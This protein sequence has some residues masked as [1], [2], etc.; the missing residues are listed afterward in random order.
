MAGSSSQNCIRS[1]ADTSARLPA[2]TKVDR[3]KPRRITVSSSGMP[4]APDW[5]KKPIRP[6]PGITGDS[7]ALSDR[8]GS[9]LMT[10]RQFG[11]IT[12]IPLAR[13]SATSS[14]CSSRPSGPAS[15]N[16]PLTTTRPSTPWPAQSRTT[17]STWAAGTATSARSTGPGRSATEAYVGTPRIGSVARGFTA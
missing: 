3:P 15:A 4:S 9:V 5:E 12:R 1:L 8:A 10:P 2:E 13:A 7:E 6:R 11:P 16:P 14:R 17:S